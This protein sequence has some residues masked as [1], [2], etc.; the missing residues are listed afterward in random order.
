MSDRRTILYIEDDLGSQRLVQRVLESNQFEVLLAEDGMQGIDIAA[1]QSPDLILMDINLPGMNGR[2]VTTRLRALPNFSNIPIVALTAH[3]GPGCRE[4][5]LVAGCDGFISK[6][7]DVAAFPQQVRDYLD[8]YR[9]ALGQEEQVT[10]LQRH[11]EEVVAHLQEKAQELEEANQRLRELDRMKSNFV[12]LVSHEL[13]TPLTLLEGYAHLLEDQLKSDDGVEYP[14]DLYS[15][16]RGLGVG[17]S[18]LSR[19]VSEII[20][21]SRI[22]SGS[23]E[24][25]IGPVRVANVVNEVREEHTPIL[26]ERNLSLTVG[27]LHELPVIEADGKQLGVALSNVVGNAIKF[28]PDGGGI[29]ISGRPVGDAVDLIVKDSGIGVPVEEQRRIFDQFYVLGE[30][31]HHSSSKTAFGGGGLGLGLA[32]TKGIIEAHAGRIWVESE[33]RDPERRP[34]STFHLVLPLKQKRPSAVFGQN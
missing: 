26:R 17:V 7:I 5:A 33:G 4:R 9:E 3:S 11:V 12:G 21:M 14:A 8:G 20:N 1:K 32:I 34:G 25:S 18:R 16:V 13:R 2:A 6:P 23:L 29:A 31:D 19:A 22:A 28:T 27:E 30:I 24:L 10:H 15:M